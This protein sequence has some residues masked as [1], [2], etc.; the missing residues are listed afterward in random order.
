MSWLLAIHLWKL[1]NYVL[2]A[3]LWSIYD[4]GSGVATIWLFV[5]PIFVKDWLLAD[6]SVIFWLVYRYTVCRKGI[7]S[8]IWTLYKML[9][10]IIVT[11]PD[12]WYLN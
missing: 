6:I 2:F 1:I 4:D 8:D 5:T 12:L 11:L 3:Y 7:D 9:S 10:I